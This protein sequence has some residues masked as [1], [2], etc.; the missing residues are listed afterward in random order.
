MRMG[1]IASRYTW[2]HLSD[3]FEMNNNYNLGYPSRNIKV[4][5]RP[6]Y[7]GLKIYTI[8]RVLSRYVGLK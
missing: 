7:E 2:K 5:S 8:A 6:E 4:L 3:K 1:I